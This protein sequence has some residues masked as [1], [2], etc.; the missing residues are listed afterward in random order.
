MISGRE[1]M[2]GMGVGAAAVGGEERSDEPATAKAV[3]RPPAPDP[4]VVA[5]PDAPTVHRGIQAQDPG[6][7]GSMLGAR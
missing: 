2:M 5:K 3:E 4:E 7:D 1:G 6:G